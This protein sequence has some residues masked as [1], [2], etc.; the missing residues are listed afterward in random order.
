MLNL[1]G[2]LPLFLS[3]VC[4]KKT[5]LGLIS[6]ALRSGTPI[7]QIT[8]CPLLNRFLR[9]NHG[10][11]VVQE[12][13]DEAGLPKTPT[14][15]LLEDEQYMY[16]VFYSPTIVLFWILTPFSRYYCVGASTAFSIVNNMDK[17]MV[18]TK[19]LVG[20]QYHIHGIG[21]VQ[22]GGYEPPTPGS[23]YPNPSKEV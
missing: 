20:E 22:K 10:F 14:V 21:I 13:D 8:P 7:P 15:D 4:E 23:V 9:Y 11:N 6:T 5:I 16:G 2:F 3:D 1:R 12:E 17:L 19:E 18:A